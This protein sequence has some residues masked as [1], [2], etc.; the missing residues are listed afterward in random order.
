MRFLIA[1]LMFLLP[2]VATCQSPLQEHELKIQSPKALTSFDGPRT[3]HQTVSN[4]AYLYILGG[5]RWETDHAVF[6]P[7]VQVTQI[8]ADGTLGPWQTT[9]EMSVARTGLASVCVKSCIYAAGGS[10]DKW[11]TKGTVESARFQPDGKIGKWATEKYPL[12]TPR[13]NFDLIVRELSDGRTLLYAV[14]GVGQVGLNTVHFDSVEYAEVMSDGSL[15]EW[16]SAS[17]DMKGGRSTPAAFLWKDC[18][19]ICGGWG[20]RN[21]DDVFSDVQFAH[22]AKNGDLDAWQTSPFPLRMRLYG[23]TA[24]VVTKGA[25]SFAI[26]VA[27]SLGEGNV[28]SSIQYARL[29]DDGSVGPWIMSQ[30][31][32]EQARWGHSSIAIGSRIYVTG[33]SASGS[34]FL[35]DVQLLE[36][37]PVALKTSAE[38]KSA[39]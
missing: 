27:G 30:T 25:N 5:Y 12:R 2:T 34:S 14:G 21:F 3:S 31:R 28:I 19:H 4:G 33:G 20:D 9:S 17:F 13:S 29:G 18:L 10:D 16:K 23:H 35:C 37:D 38:G 15:S 11:T 36:V 39:K 32:I 8:K 24:S 6:Y 7:S 22:L 26:S 1:F